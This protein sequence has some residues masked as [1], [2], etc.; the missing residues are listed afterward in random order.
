MTETVWPEKLK[1]FAIL[2]F[3][4][5]ICQLLNQSLATQSIDGEPASP[6]SIIGLQNLE[7]QSYEIGAYILTR[8]LGV[9]GCFSFTLRP[10]PGLILA[11]ARSLER[12]L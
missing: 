2:P 9:W 6:G 7:H 3:T 8:S 11:S 4:E 5:K 10:G 1:V 12:Y